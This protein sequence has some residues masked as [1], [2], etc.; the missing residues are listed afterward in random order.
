M[1]QLSGKLYSLLSP[2]AVSLEEE[3]FL[4]MALI[5]LLS[6][7]IEKF[8][9]LRS[10]E[11][12]SSPGSCEGGV[13]WV[14]YSLGVLST[15][16]ISSAGDSSFCTSSLNPHLNSGLPQPGQCPA[17]RNLTDLFFRINMTLFL[18]I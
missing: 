3:L 5:I 10:W 12:F 6:F 4:K 14:F 7:P 8:N 18:V 1:E 2:R 17:P 9:K 16:P 11:G 15:L 13:P